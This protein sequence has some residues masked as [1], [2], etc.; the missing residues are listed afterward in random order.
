MGW[1]VKVESKKKSA[2]MHSEPA[3]FTDRKQSL[4]W[5][6]CPPGMLIKEFFSKKRI[7]VFGGKQEKEGEKKLLMKRPEKLPS[8]IS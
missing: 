8:L 1:V 6:R 2:A 4:V 7:G 3:Q 5:W